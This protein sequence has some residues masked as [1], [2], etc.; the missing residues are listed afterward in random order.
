MMKSKIIQSSGSPEPLGASIENKGVNFS[1][2]AK[3]ASSVELLL[4]DNKNDIQPS[5]T[6]QLSPIENK[7]YYYWHIFISGIGAGQ[8]YAYRVDGEYN[9]SETFAYDKSKVLID[10]Y[11]KGIYASNYD[12]VKACKFGVDNL[13]NSYKSVVVDSSDYDW[14]GDTPPNLSLSDLVIY[15]MHVGGFTKSPSSGLSEDLR[16][17]YAGVIEKIPYLKSLGINAVELLPV[18]S[19]DTQDAPL[20]KSNYWGYSPIN[21]FSIHNDY[22]IAKEP[23][24]AIKE[25]K[26]LV[27]ALHKAGIEVI[28]DVVY[29]HTTESNY[30]GPCL[31]MKGFENQAYYILDP[32]NKSKHLDFTGCGNSF[33]SNHSIPR[34]MILDSL[35]YWVKEMHIDGFRFDL[36]STFSRSEVGEP[37]TNPPVVWSIESEPALAC[38]KLIAEAWD[39]SGLYELGNFTGDKWAEWNGKYRDDIRKFIKGEKGLVSTIASRIVGSPDVFQKST[40]NVA[41]SIHFISCHDGFTMNDLVSYNQKHNAAN[42][43]SNLDGANDNYSWNCGIEGK[44]DDEEIERL[45]LKQLKNFFAI[46]FLSQGTTMILMGDEARRTKNGNNNTY[47][48]DGEINWLDWNLLKENEELFNFVASI[49]S[50]TQKSK[51]LRY[52]KNMDTVD[53]KDGTPFISWHGTQLNEPDWNSNSVA[54]GFEYHYPEV[55]ERI[56]VFMNMFWEDLEFEIPDPI[57]GKWVLQ[58]DTSQDNSETCKLFD[59]EKT[60]MVESRSIVAFVDK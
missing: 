40:Y 53:R 21:F 26:N 17:T 15:E 20:F 34:R 43:E 9:P 18:F 10:P 38:T 13:E 5:H 42:G 37:M 58:I 3:N 31:S 55:K 35:K 28:L 33:N 32:H 51:V 29:N 6:I 25:F 16:G 23:I 41:K 22:S 48:I 12:R 50:I 60:I 1:V 4:F 45:R 7:S 44:T 14:E 49:I 39:A 57:Y 30:S 46:S 54:L 19:F 24:S 36:A 56:L 47:C 59:R 8:F 52:S 2:F 27:K 11:A